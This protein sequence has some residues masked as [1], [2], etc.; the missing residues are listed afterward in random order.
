MEAS[1]ILGQLR[2]SMNAWD[3]DSLQGQHVMQGFAAAVQVMEV[4][5]RDVAAHGAA[6]TEARNALRAEHAAHQQKRNGRE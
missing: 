6:L 4:V 3:Q 1:G 2:A 5:I